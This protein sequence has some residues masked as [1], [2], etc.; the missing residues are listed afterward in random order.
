MARI[1]FSIL[2][3]VPLSIPIPALSFDPGTAPCSNSDHALD[4]NFS[5]ALDCELGS[6]LDFV[7]SRSRSKEYLKGKRLEGNE[8]I[9]DVRKFL[10]AQD[11]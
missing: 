4:S 6:V 10:D 5:P 9:A 7:L 11:E 2:L 3:L 8:A 1:R